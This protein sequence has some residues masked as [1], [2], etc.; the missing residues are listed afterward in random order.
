MYLSECLR[1]IY[2][3]QNNNTSSA[4]EKLIA[5]LKQRKQVISIGQQTNGDCGSTA[6]KYQTSQG[7]EFRL[8][9]EKPTQL[10]DGSYTEGEGF[11]PDVYVEESLPWE[12][13]PD[14][15]DKAM[16]LI[17]SDKLRSVNNE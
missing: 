14:E 8:A 11:S 16:E 13:L 1:K 17:K 2:I 5:L 3:L 9:T 4:A 6:Y 7:I 10:P 12:N 15:F